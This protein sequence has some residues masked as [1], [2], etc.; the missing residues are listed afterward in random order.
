VVSRGEK[1]VNYSSYFKIIHKKIMAKDKIKE[2]EYKIEG[3][4]RMVKR[5]VK[6]ARNNRKKSLD[7]I[8]GHDYLCNCD[9]CG[10]Y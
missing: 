3:L 8:K 4:R 9:F 2:L 5:K 1:Q 7:K 6:R 10:G